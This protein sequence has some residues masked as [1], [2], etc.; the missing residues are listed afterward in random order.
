MAQCNSYVEGGGQ[1][2]SFKCRE[3]SG[4]EGPCATPDIPRSVLSRARWIEEQNKT[5][6]GQFQGPAETT[7]Q[8][9]TDGATPPPKGEGRVQDYPGTV[10][11]RGA[12][13]ASRLASRPEMEVLRLDW[14]PPGV[15]YLVPKEMF[16]EARSE[17]TPNDWEVVIQKGYV[18]KIDLPG[19]PT[20][21]REHDQ[22]LPQQNDRPYVQPAVIEDLQ[23]R[24]EVGIE[25]YGTPLQPMNGRDTVK[26]A[27]EE[28]M[29]LTVYLRGM[30]FEREE[31]ATK[32]YLIEGLLARMLSNE[33]FPRPYV[34]SMR[35]A[36]AELAAWL[37]Q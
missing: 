28:A 26:D 29:D 5:A 15:A 30:M 24:I 17:F 13:E 4:H 8:R 11:T 35:A 37:E 36:A 33:Q 16:E 1:S 22:P 34:E 31:M 23:H 25:R 19:E 6:L 12:Q 2:M 21:Q 18:M 7:A 10:P 27:Y 20:K 14:M 9:Y 32:A 3:E